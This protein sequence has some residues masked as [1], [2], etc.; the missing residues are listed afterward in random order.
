MIAGPD[1]PAEQVLDLRLGETSSDPREL[2]LLNGL[3]YFS[4]EGENGKRDLY[5][6]CRRNTIVRSLSG[7]T[8]GFSPENLIINNSVL[9]FSAKTA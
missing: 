8:E 4:A 9:Y 6:E 7:S 5:W 2:T 1:Q 3:I